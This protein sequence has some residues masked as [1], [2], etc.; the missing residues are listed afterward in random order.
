MGYVR[1]TMSVIF[2]FNDNLIDIFRT[3]CMG[4]ENTS[5]CSRQ[6]GMYVQTGRTTTSTVDN[7]YIIL[8]Y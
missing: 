5:Q 1:L 6:V 2:S 7:S 4:S 8:I 3:H